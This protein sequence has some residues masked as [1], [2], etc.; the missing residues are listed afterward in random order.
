M[1]RVK[2]QDAEYKVTQLLTLSISKF[3][4]GMYSGQNPR[5]GIWAVANAR[6][7]SVKMLFPNMFDDDLPQVY[8]ATPTFIYIKQEAL[9]EP[10]LPPLWNT[11]GVGNSYGTLTC[12]ARDSLPPRWRG[13]RWSLV[14]YA[15]VNLSWQVHRRLELTKNEKCKYPLCNFGNERYFLQVA[16]RNAPDPSGILLERQ[17]FQ[18]RGMSSRI[19]YGKLM[20][21]REMNFVV[22]RKT[23]LQIIYPN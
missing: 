23:L 20:D 21:T 22:L 11:R 10:V 1:P 9:T 12:P 18:L 8:A 15:P 4:M 14:N 6:T 2:I 16:Y 5:L 13:H 3:A 17:V 19:V 7:E